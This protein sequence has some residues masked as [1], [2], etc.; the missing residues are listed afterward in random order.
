MNQHE[1]KPSP[2]ADEREARSAKPADEQGRPAP[3]ATKGK[4]DV[5]VK[6]AFVVV[7]AAGGALIWRLQRRDPK[8]GWPTDLDAA[9]RQAKKDDR[10]VI[11]FLM[12][13]SLPPGG[14]A[15]WN[16]RNTLAKKA[17]R[18]AISQG[19]VICVQVRLDATLKSE[20]ARKYRITKLPT[21]LLLGPDG[22]ERNRRE[23]KIGETDFRNGFLDA[24]IVQKPAVANSSP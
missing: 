17:N 8:L 7:L 22:K 10:Q 21:M 12:S 1:A 13:V 24:T 9:L 11:V 16:I 4:R 3:P 2:P 6:L 19:G 5:L 18:D 14:D 20:T 23:G 15:E